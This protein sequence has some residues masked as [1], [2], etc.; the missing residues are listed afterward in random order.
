[1][2]VAACHWSRHHDAPQAKVYATHHF[3]ERPTG[4]VGRGLGTQRT[5]D[6]M[7][8]FAI[9]SDAILNGHNPILCYVELTA[10]LT[11]A[12]ILSENDVDCALGR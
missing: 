6:S 1:M 3:L 8:I 9:A 12:Q 4:G 7:I 10:I 5:D 11:A 2:G